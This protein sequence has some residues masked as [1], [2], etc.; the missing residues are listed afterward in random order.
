MLWNEDEKLIDFSGVD[1]QELVMLF[2]GSQFIGKYYGTEII[3]WIKINKDINAINVNEQN[4]NKLK[5]YL[6][7]EFEIDS[8]SEKMD[9]KKFI[10]YYI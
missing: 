8:R 1:G 6:K 2:L 3:R 5:F 4:E 9:F 7:Q 10:Q